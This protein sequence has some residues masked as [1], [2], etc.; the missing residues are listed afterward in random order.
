MAPWERLAL[1]KAWPVAGNRALGHAFLAMAEP[2]IYDGV[3]G[4]NEI[5]DVLHMKRKIDEMARRKQPGRNVKLGPGGIREIEL[6]VQSLQ[7]CYGSRIPEVRERSTTG[8]LKALCERS[9]LSPEEDEVLRRAYLFLRDV[10][11]KLQMVQD[12]QTHSLPVA[13]DEFA[14]CASLLGYKERSE[15]AAAQFERDYSYHTSNVSRLFE[16][17]VSG[18]GLLRRGTTPL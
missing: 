9:L 18:A 16:Q 4:S 7:V 1:L 6:I 12:R 2:F 17:M 8:A 3:F 13:D 14:A 15:S 5:E 11:N 10:E